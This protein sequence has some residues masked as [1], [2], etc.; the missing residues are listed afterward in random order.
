MTDT[1]DQK[2]IAYYDERARDYDAFY[3]GR[4]P[5]IPEPES[6]KKDV[7]AISALATTF[8]R[9]HVVDIG[10]GTGFW[11]PHYAKN[12]SRLTLLDQSR[13]MLLVCKHRAVALG[14]LDKCDFHNEDFFAC[15]LTNNLY[16]GAVIGFFMSHLTLEQENIFFHRLDGMLQPHALVLFID[17]AWTPMRAHYRKKQGMQERVL[18]N[19]RTFNIFKRYF[20]LSEA[21]EMCEGHGF[22]VSLSYGGEVFL[23]MIGEK[24]V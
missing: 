18:H 20:T 19:G 6:Y 15:N 7:V 22:I 13:N 5:A 2:L 8:G 11:L 10:C 21:R 3:F 1:S 17:S 14:I 12:C 16:D 24:H 9:G 4:G 23:A